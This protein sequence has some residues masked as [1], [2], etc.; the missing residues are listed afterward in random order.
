MRHAAYVTK[1]FNPPP[2]PGPVP[3]ALYCARGPA[4]V[5]PSTECF[6]MLS[7]SIDSRPAF[8]PVDDALAFLQGTDW[9]ALA[10]RALAALLLVVAVAHAL[11]ARLW[12]ARGRL[13]PIIR[14]LAD[15]LAALAAR[16]PEPL[17][18]ASPRPALIAALAAAGQPP[19]ALAKASRPALVA[20]ARRL[21]LIG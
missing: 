19:A 1:C 8:P 14:R 13:A 3:V 10:D 2:G 15:G 4:M 12:S 9:P 21:A 16:L 11:A 7:L 5:R 17:S 6:P 18:A 20:R